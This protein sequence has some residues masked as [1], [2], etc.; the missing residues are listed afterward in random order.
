MKIPLHPVESQSLK[1]IG[2]DPASKTLAVKFHS[3][4]VYHYSNVSEKEEAA[5]LKAESIGRH[6][7]GKIMPNHQHTKIE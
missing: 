2:Y 4:A 1:S 7:M 5:L 3:G 6:F